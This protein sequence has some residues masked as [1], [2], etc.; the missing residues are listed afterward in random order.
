MIL[1]MKPQAYILLAAAMLLF[2]VRWMLSWVLAA[3]VHELFH[4]F[5]ILASGGSIYQIQIGVL[6]ARIETDNCSPGREIVRALAGPIG[7]L[8]LLL[9]IRFTPRLAMCGCIQSA[10]NLV[11]IYPLDGGRVVR[12]ALRRFI[13]KQADRI[14]NVPDVMVSSCL[15]FLGIYTTFVWKFGLLPLLLSTMLLCRTIKNSLQSKCIESTIGLP[16]N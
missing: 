10:C 2:P 4:S 8:L 11:P 1:R 6:G 5:A 13:P 16:E 7:G 9:T 14:I 3:L 15:F 12:A